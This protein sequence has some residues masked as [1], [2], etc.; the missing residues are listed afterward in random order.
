MIGQA[1]HGSG[2]TGTFILNMLERIDLSKKHLQA[3]VICH[4]RELATQTKQVAIQLGRNMDGLQ[5]VL[6]VPKR[7]KNNP[8]KNDVVP[9][10]SQWSSQVCIGTPGVILFQILNYD[11]NYQKLRD[12][13]LV[14]SFLRYFKL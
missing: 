11:Q 13:N 4:T 3:L 5:I 8:D 9:T 6:A 1:H 10:M 2:K 14:R 7:D 12:A